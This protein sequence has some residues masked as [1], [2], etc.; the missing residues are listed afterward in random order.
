MGF[1]GSG[2]IRR[3]LCRNSETQEF[4]HV[5]ERQPRKWVRATKWQVQ[6]TKSHAKKNPTFRWG[7][8]EAVGFEPTVPKRAQLISSQSRYD[9]FDTLP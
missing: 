5:V 6:C 9:H 3:H 2:G 7:L 1:G 8:A 4:T